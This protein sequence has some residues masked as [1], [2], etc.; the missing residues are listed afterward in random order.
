MELGDTLRDQLKFADFL[1]KRS[2]DSDYTF[3]QHIREIGGA[4]EE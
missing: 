2:K 3:L 1:R 4:I